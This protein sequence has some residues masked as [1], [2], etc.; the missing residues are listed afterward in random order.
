MASQ[1]DVDAWLLV[2]TLL[3]TALIIACGCVINN[4]LDRSIDSKMKRTKS[5]ALVTGDISVSAA[6][7]FAAVIGITGVATLL[8]FVN[9][10]T[11]A[12]GVFGLFAYVVL[13]SYVKRH[14]VHGTLVGTISGATPPVAGYIAVTNQFDTALLLLFLILVFWQM[15]HFYAIAL[16]RLK[17]YQAAGIPVLPSVK[18]SRQTTSQ[19]VVYIIMFTIVASCLTIYGYT[20]MVYLIIMLLLGAIWLWYWLAD[21]SNVDRWARKMFFISLLVLMGWYVTLS[22]GSFFV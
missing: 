21:K 10:R 19:M 14:S 8:L 16:Y 5:R 15:P 13:Y 7:T 9:S 22:I 17:E 12:V 2:A 1:G 11:A 20:S 3:G 6:K 18:G 4:Y